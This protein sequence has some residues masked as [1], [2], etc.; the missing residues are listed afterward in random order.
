[1]RT[2]RIG[3]ARRSALVVLVSGTALALAACSGGAPTP[4]V[5]TPATTPSVSAATVAPTVEPTVS[6][7]PT[8]AAVAATV[9]PLT[10]LPLSGT[11]T[12]R[13][14][15]AVKIENTSE[16]RPQEGLNQADM[17]WETIVEYDVSRLLAVFQSQAPAEV[18]PVRS[19]RPMDMPIAAPLKGLFAYS[20]GQQ[21]ILALAEKSS[22]QTF[23]FDSGNKAFYRVSTRPAPHNVYLKPA[24]LWSQASSSRVAPQQQFAF[25]ATAA[26]A[27]AVTGGTA[28]TTLTYKLSTAAKPMWK[29]DATSGT[30]LRFE[31]TTK[32]TTVTSG[33]GTSQIAAVNV[34]TIVAAHPPTQWGAQTP[35]TR[36]P[37]Y[38]LT[39]AS[40]TGTLATG[41]KTIP[42]KWS[43]GSS[44]TDPM[45][46]TLA[47]GTP[48]TLA[49]G[50][51][52][53]ELV[54]KGTGSYTIG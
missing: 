19:V 47:D 45:V 18:G 28:A 23:S 30:W 3:H 54:P 29:W 22:M 26:Q 4:A 35:G 8:P 21:G 31:G 20:G 16:A 27:S 25:A 1:M 12:N 6:A 13:P 24:A 49:P 11:G 14:A 7:T 32:A 50:N 15:L 52:W 44:D 5:S 33:K 51:T 43:K 34:L 42:V 46:L 39:G 2:T 37:T 17:V 41:G 9:W 36:V 48:A 53:V 38:T 10:G 40:G